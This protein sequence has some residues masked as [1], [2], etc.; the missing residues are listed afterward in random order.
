MLKTFFFSRN[1][2][3]CQYPEE[4]QRDAVVLE[5]VVLE[6]TEVLENK[7]VLEEQEDIK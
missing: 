7:E 3:K 1:N 6:N 4:K 5:D 2:I